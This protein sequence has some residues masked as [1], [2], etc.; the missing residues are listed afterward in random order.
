[1]GD[2]K[3]PLSGTPRVLGS[4]IVIVYIF[5]TRAVIIV[6]IFSRGCFINLMV[7]LILVAPSRVF[8]GQT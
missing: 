7:T 3:A 5:T 1:M 6:L 8:E 4:K 2:N